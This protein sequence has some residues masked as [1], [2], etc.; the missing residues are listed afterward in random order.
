LLSCAR[1]LRLAT[2]SVLQRHERDWQALADQLPA[3]RQRA[4]ERVGQRLERSALRLGLLD[5][6]LVLERGYA[7]ITDAQGRAVTSP[8]QAQPGD[9]L[10]A[11]VAHGSIDLRV[12]APVSEQ[13]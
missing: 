1:R 12:I 7:W 6:S 5:P 4:L 3:A 10:R 13:E 8:A 2:R 9:A 11:T